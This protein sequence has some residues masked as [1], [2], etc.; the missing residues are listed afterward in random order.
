ML[1]IRPAKEIQGTVR[2]PPSGDLF[3]VA[4]VMAMAAKT[5][6][7]ISPV[8][9]IPLVPW[10]EK[11][12][13]GH[14]LF[15]CDAERCSVTPVDEPNAPVIALSYE[16]LPYRDFVVFTLLGR[17]KTLLLDPLPKA[18]LDRWSKY[19]ADL[20]CGIRAGEING[21]P[22]ISLEGGENF[23]VRE[24]VKSIE[25][26]HPIV[27]LGLGL[28]KQVSLVTDTVFTSPVRQ[29]LSAFGYSLS[30][31]NN[32]HDKIEDPL[33]RRMRFLQIGK[34]SDEPL[35][36]TV[37]ADFS[38]RQD[39]TPDIRVPGD[40]VLC[41]IV[42]VAKCLVPKGSLIIENAGL[43]SWSTTTLSLFRKMGGVVATQESE[44]TSFGSC[45]TVT[46]TKFGHCGRKVE[47][48]PL[49]QYASQLPAM[50]VLAAFGAGQS[51]FR[52]LSD[53]R[54]DE[55][56]GISQIIS[57]VKLLGARHGE[58]PDGL[59]VDGGRQF[60]GFDLPD[61]VPAQVA[62]SLAVAGLRCM[63]K[64]AIND[65][66]IIRRWPRFGELLNSICEYRD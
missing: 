64:T 61:H 7:H 26:V 4:I 62:A 40:D 54:N 10:W 60:D 22:S 18:R 55:P 14:V 50:V 11:A 8:R 42:A 24:T 15:S 38:K 6:A 12:L 56:D 43:E 5:A 17:G 1:E 25:E 19:A 53:L 49:F 20:G 29:A 2:L 32:L 34:K 33:V 39:I 48:R 27:G 45:G 23:R 35:Q 46:L 28:G 9:D 58:M 36:F 37:A 31:T 59:V 63:G 3:F 41:A 65:E 52:G 47:C 13:V 30:V 57:C 21:K 44:N 51:V 16:E 66:S